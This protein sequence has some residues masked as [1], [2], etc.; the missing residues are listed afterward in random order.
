MEYIIQSNCFKETT[1]NTVNYAVSEY[2]IKILYST[3]LYLK[4][5]AKYIYFLTKK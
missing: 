2:D 4:P 5:K 3:F 1:Y